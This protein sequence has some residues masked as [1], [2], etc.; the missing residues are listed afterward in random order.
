MNKMMKTLCA[1][2]VLVAMSS[3][4]SAKLPAPSDE[5]KAK[6]AEASAK[7]AWAGKVEGF[8]LCQA[9]DK[10]AAHYKKLPLAKGAVAPVAGTSVVPAA[11]IAG[12]S[13]VASAP[14]V[15]AAPAACVDPGPFV[16]TPMVAMPAGA[17]SGVAP[18]ATPAASAAKKS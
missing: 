8:K 4:V 6:A 14:A 10:V 17:A 16:Y 12:A 2:A 1:A 7:T 15:V 3:V 13:A 9:Q 5:A 18:A 11:P